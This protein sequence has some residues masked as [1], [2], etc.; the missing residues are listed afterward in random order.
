MTTRGYEDPLVD[1]ALRKST[2]VWLQWKRRGIARSL[3]VWY[4]KDGDRLL[5]LSGERQQRIPAPSEL[6]ECTI[7]VR[8]KG[9][10]ILLAE[11]PVDVRVIGPESEEWD[12]AA[13]RLAEKRLNI[14]GLPRETAGRWRASCVILELTLKAGKEED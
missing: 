4:V 1:E 7:A 6:R 9:R 3:P 14:P 8:S 13:I 2:I 5:V 11:L 12:E 10:D